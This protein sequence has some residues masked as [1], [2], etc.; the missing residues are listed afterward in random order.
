MRP[1]VLAVM[2][3]QPAAQTPAVPP[4]DSALIVVDGATRPDLV[5]QWSV[6]A[7]VFRVFAGGPRQLPSSIAELVSA[8]EQA[9][10]TREADAAQKADAVCQERLSKT[11]ARLG[12][13]PAAVVE[14]RMHEITMGCR[15]DTLRARDTVLSGV[16]PEAAAA[17]R[18]FAESTKSGT[19]I[20]LPKKKLARFLE[21]E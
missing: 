1:L 5:P 20:S 15:R 4:G 11:L 13:D 2:L 19:S 7:Y 3:L 21:P 8:S 9:L 14:D 10:V 16:N 6:W 17:L 18:A 12:P